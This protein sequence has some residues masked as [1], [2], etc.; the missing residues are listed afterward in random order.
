MGD[1]EELEEAKDVFGTPKSDLTEQMRSAK[2]VGRVRINNRIGTVLPDAFLGDVMS[3]R[4]Q[5]IDELDHN[6]YFEV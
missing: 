2:N 5:E 4:E 6:S 3:K 1:L